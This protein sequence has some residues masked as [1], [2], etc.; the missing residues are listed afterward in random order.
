[1]V[2]I[3][4]SLRGGCGAPAVVFVDVCL[5]VC[6]D[7]KQPLWGFG[8]LA[9]QSASDDRPSILPTS[10]GT[11]SYAPIRPSAYIPETP[12]ALPTPKPY[13]HA[14]FLPKPESNNMRHFRQSVA[15]K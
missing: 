14:P 1:M 6:P 12:D 10:P 15:P 11:K 2:S 5:R 13:L 7:I 4:S 3:G 9:C 8:F